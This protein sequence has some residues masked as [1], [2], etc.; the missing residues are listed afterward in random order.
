MDGGGETQKGKNGW[1]GE[2]ERFGQVARDEISLCN[3]KWG[4]RVRVR[5]GQCSH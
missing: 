1:D 3:C 2:I 4:D 5:K